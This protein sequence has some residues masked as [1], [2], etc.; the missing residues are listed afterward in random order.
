M[1][2]EPPFAELQLDDKDQDTEQQGKHS[3]KDALI[4]QKAML[5]NLKDIQRK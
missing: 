5:E 2:A 1:F 3:I 4:N